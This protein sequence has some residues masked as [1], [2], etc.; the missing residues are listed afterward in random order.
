MIV[1]DLSGRFF[2]ADG[3]G[4]R[5]CRGPRWTRT[6]GFR[7]GLAEAIVSQ[8]PHR[9]GTI[10][11]AIIDDAL[12]E[13]DLV[14]LALLI[15]T[16]PAGFV[17]SH[18]RLLAKQ[19]HCRPSGGNMSREC[20][21]RPIGS[22]SSLKF[23]SSGA[24]DAPSP[25]RGRASFNFLMADRFL[26]PPGPTRRRAFF[27]TYRRARVPDV[28]IAVGEKRG[29]YEVALIAGPHRRGVVAR[30]APAFDVEG[31]P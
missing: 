16:C 12:H 21:E 15:G 6:Q 11:I 20:S 28:A 9:D 7:A 22:F 26:A 25:R 30:P 14:I 18:G 17:R 5:P 1:R 29:V 10:S 3:D 13:G 2:G 19:G 8:S 27:P 23:S 31:R 4:N 24:R